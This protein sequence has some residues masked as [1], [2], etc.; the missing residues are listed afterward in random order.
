MRQPHPSDPI[1][2]ARVGMRRAAIR[3]QLQA[4]AEGKSDHIPD[5]ASDS[6]FDAAHAVEAITAGLREDSEPIQLLQVAFKNSRVA[7]NVIEQLG[8][9]PVHERVGNARLVGA[10]RLYEA[11][12]WL[13]PLLSAR[14][15]SVANAAARALGRIGGVRCAGAL[16]AAIQ[17]HGVSRRLVSELA[18]GAPDQYI[19]TALGEPQRPGV[20]PALAIAAGL[21]KRRTAISPLLV[22]LQRGSRKERVIS[23]RALGWIGAGTA[24]PVIEEALGD[25]DWKIRMSAAKALGALGARSSRRA[26]ED[27]YGDRNPRVRMAAHQAV[28]RLGRGA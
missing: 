27:L 2:R 28:R 13:T 14:D 12:A 26:L 7:D 8:A 4:V 25:R 19:E 23:C 24:I 3:R 21:R 15:S 17:R 10:L 22:L 6:A 11:V 18:R 16:V 9:K 5:D 20:R 1:R